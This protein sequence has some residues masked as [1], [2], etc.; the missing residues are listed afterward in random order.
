MK[1]SSDSERMWGEMT[2]YSHE[3][4]A[5]DQLWKNVMTCSEKLVLR[6]THLRT[7]VWDYHFIW[8]FSSNAMYF[9]HFKVWLKCPRVLIKSTKSVDQNIKRDAQ[10]NWE[11]KP[12]KV[13]LDQQT[14]FINVICTWYKITVARKQRIERETQNKVKKKL[15]IMLIIYC[16]HTHIKWQ[17]WI[18][19][20]GV[21]PEHGMADSYK[22]SFGGSRQETVHTTF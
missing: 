1:S 6:K 2:S 18:S 19:Y 4:S 22:L 17:K 21:T 14:Y 3:K 10:M 8:C 5:G 16:L 20:I 15:L 7:V 11:L 13:C 12:E 9:N